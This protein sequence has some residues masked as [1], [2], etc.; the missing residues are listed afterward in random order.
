MDN[1]LKTVSKSDT[2]L[3]VANYI[4]LF[5]GEDL[6]GEHFTEKTVLESSYTKTGFLH[7]DFE[8]G[9]DPDGVG[10]DSNEVLGYV[11][12]KTARVD[13]TGV[14]V[15]RSLKRQARYMAALEHL[16]ENKKIGTSSQAVASQVVREGKAIAQWPLMRDTLTFTP[17]EPRMLSDNVLH[18]AKCLLD[19]FPSSKTL[20]IINHADAAKAR[21]EEARSL[22][23]IEGVL[24]DSGLTRAASTALVSR[25]KSMVQGD[26]APKA[27]AEVI[28]ATFE[29]FKLSRDH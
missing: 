20:A 8:H 17:A 26:P 16:I 24:R 21:I 14:F 13:E 4:V 29:Q 10:M 25:V 9:L 27:R 2:E 1:T 3:R 7:V 5:G 6:H 22:H 28:S 11:D 19:E 18:A 23:E 12:W 15:E